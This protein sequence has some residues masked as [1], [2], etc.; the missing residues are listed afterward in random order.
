M[1]VVWSNRANISFNKYVLWYSNNANIQVAQDFITHIKQCENSICV[2]P[3]IARTS[4]EITT[5]REY[6][7]QKYPFLISYKIDTEIIT[8]TSFL[9]QRKDR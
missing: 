8:I 5:L 7:V 9:H 3:Y 4:P 1:Q 2:N 6:V